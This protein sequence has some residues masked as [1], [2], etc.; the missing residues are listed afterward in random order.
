MIER[1]IIE[2]DIMNTTQP[3]KT[4]RRSAAAVAG[5]IIASIVL[6][7]DLYAYSTSYD[8]SFTMDVLL[9][10]HQL[11]MVLGVLFA[12]L[13]V[14]KRSCG[15]ILTSAILL[16]VSALPLFQYFFIFGV[17]PVLMYIGYANQS[18]INRKKS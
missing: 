9:I 1:K 5:A 16:T 2:D 17:A 11:P 12:W 3:D 10:I 7:M 15:L 8:L 13:G 14:T 18:T 4:R 6:V